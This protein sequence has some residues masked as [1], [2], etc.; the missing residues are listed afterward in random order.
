MRIQESQI[1]TMEQDHTDAHKL[2]THCYACHVAIQNPDEHRNSPIHIH[3][4]KHESWELFDSLS[5]Q[6]TLTNYFG[7]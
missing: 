5:A 7:T 6:I 3:H 2:V 4:T 1:D